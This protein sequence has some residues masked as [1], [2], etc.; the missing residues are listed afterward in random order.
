MGREREPAVLTRAQEGLVQ[1]I[2]RH[3]P[4]VERKARG[5]AASIPDENARKDYLQEVRI[6]MYRTIGWLVEEQRRMNWPNYLATIP[7]KVFLSYYRRA[8]SKNLASL[9]DH[10]KDV[11]RRDAQQY[12]QKQTQEGF[13]ELVR[14]TINHEDQAR[15][16]ELVHRRGLNYQ[17]AA[18]VL[19]VPIGTVRSRVFRAKA[20]LEAS[21]QKDQLLRIASSIGRTRAESEEVQVIREYGD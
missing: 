4:E 19:G 2:Y 17:Q 8:K 6:R 12:A 18:K 10:V 9:D 21:G 16:F 20:K 5:H 1:S 11:G 3:L 13:W 15:V 14:N 7:K